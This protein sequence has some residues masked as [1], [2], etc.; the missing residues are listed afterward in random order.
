VAKI[1]WASIRRAPKTVPRRIRYGWARS[2]SGCHCV[3]CGSEFGHFLRFRD[4]S[5]GFSL[6]L[7]DS[8][9]VTGDVEH[10]ECP[11]CG[12]GDR[13]RHMFMYFDA[14]GTWDRFEGARV[15]H[16]APERFLR[17]RLEASAREYIPGDLFPSEECVR[18]IDVTDIDAGDATLDAVVCNH[19]LEHVGDPRV[20]LRE[21]RR[22]LAPGGLAV[23]QTPFASR[24]AQTLV[25]PK[26]TTDALRRERYGQEDHVRL[27]GTDL[28]RLIAD[29]GFDVSVVEHSKALADV[30]VRREGVSPE[31]PLILA[32]ASRAGVVPDGPSPAAGATI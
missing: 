4:G 15:L 21:I 32:Y 14:L 26:A 23:L 7:L 20:A 29:A 6:A 13:E 31:E 3:N 24:L 11:V 9:Y 5:R 19:V 8:G 10:H 22:V 25:D 2:G 16:I 27:F 18:R 1:T 12:I 17:K 28:F 30:D